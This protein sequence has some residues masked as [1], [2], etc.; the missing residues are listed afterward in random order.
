MTSALT[1][2]TNGL[3]QKV[4]ANC[5]AA[6][7]FLSAH[8]ADPKQMV[9]LFNAYNDSGIDHILLPIKLGVLANGNEKLDK[10]PL[11]AEMLSSLTEKLV[12]GA[13]F[14][15]VDDDPAPLVGGDDETFKFKGALDLLS[16]FTNSFLRHDFVNT[17]SS[18]CLELIVEAVNKSEVMK[19]IA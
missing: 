8:S 16:H 13:G 1:D 6:L 7:A 12:D 2:S 3:N 4:I 18:K 9:T 17:P 14:S 10:A 19:K 15:E 11:A 5:S